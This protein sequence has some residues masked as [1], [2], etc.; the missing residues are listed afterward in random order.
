MHGESLRRAV[1]TDAATTFAAQLAEDWRSLDL[2]E[3]EQAMLEYT[4]KVALTASMMT[5]RDVERL[6]G[7]GWS[8]R[9]ILEITLVAC[10]YNF[11]CRLADAL[12]VELDSGIVDEELLGELDRRRVVPVRKP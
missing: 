3:K 8:D 11:M 5:E 2:P 1:G 12:G 7:V 6:R 10:H 4:E 9:E